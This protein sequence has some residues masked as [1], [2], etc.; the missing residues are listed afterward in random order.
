MQGAT[1]PAQL[2]PSVSEAP[3][4]NSR[5]SPIYNGANNGAV[6]PDANLTGTAEPD[7]AGWKDV[8]FAR[9]LSTKKGSGSQGPKRDL[10]STASTRSRR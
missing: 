2:T 7:E 6:S 8:P 9:S 3:L 5:G 1:L 4:E 10:R